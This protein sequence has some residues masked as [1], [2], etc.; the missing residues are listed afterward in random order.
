MTLGNFMHVNVNSRL[1]PIW[2]QHLFPG[3]M[4]QML[5]DMKFIFNKPEQFAYT[6]KIHMIQSLLDRICEREKE[7]P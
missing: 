4:K 7:F 3:Q 5:Y 1:Q 2:P 6:L